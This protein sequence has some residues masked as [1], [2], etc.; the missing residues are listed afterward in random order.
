[1]GGINLFAHQYG[2]QF[3]TSEDKNGVMVC[4]APVVMVVLVATAVS[5]R[6]YV[7]TLY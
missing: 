1:M 3:L 2:A 6:F 5:V 7:I 4:E